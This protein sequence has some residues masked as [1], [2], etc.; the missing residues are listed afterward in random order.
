MSKLEI[1]KMLVLSTSHVSQTTADL[2]PR[3][4]IDMISGDHQDWW[5]TFSREEGWVFYVGELKSYKDAPSDLFFVVKYAMS[6][7]CVWLMFDRDGETVDNLKT[8]EW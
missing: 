2:L 7:G 4:H 6:H 5:P 1:H 8:Y 3:N